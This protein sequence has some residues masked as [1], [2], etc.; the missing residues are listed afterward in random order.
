MSARGDKT[1]EHLL[2]VAERLFAERGVAGVSL[3]EVRL[4]AGARNTA[5]MQFH[6][7]DRAGLFRALTKR[8]MPRIAEIQLALYEQAVAQGADDDPR[9]L[10][11]VLVRPTADYL[12]M[13]PSERAW[14][15]IMG[16]LA[17]Q[18]ALH[19][20][21]MTSNTPDAGVQAGAQLQRQLT[22]TLP[23]AVARERIIILAQ[24]SVHL[25]ADHARLLDD[26]AT[27]RRHT[28]TDEFVTNLVDMLTAAMFAPA[29]APTNTNA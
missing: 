22:R 15:Q 18:P 21:Q 3:R 6:F 11:E 12:T 14:V 5:A 8:H 26:P 13:G 4:A 24:A 10:V 19:L 2:D 16:D 17:S 28:T 27:S 23:D 29:T 9:C 7:G 1:R 20:K 25:T